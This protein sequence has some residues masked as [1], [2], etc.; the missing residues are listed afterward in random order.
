M[1]DS[2]RLTA[3]LSFFFALILS[4]CAPSGVE[5]TA[6]TDDG[7]VEE[8]LIDSEAL[9]DT[10]WDTGG[11]TGWDGAPLPPPGCSG[12]ACD[13]QDPVA[14]G[15]TGLTTLANGTSG[16]V[17]WALR[18]SSICKTTF[19]RAWRHSTGGYMEALVMRETDLVTQPVL[20]TSAT[21]GAKKDS[22]MVY[23]PSGSCSSLACVRDSATGS[24]SCTDWK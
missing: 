17:S 5:G 4:A 7:T 2:L 8:G 19:V 13:G 14:M 6:P 1:T 15:C 24:Y 3:L 10:G 11:D 21:A 12:S 9:A 23:C 20:D 18:Y 16:G 22:G